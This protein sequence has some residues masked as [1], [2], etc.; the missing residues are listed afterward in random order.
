MRRALV[1]DRCTLA[2]HQLTKHVAAGSRAFP[3]LVASEGGRP[4]RLLVL[5]DMADR[6]G[7]PARGVRHVEVGQGRLDRA[8]A[9]VEHRRVHVA[10]VA[11]AEGLAAERPEPAADA[12]QRSEEHTSELQSLMRISYA[13][14]CLKINITTYIFLRLAC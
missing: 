9:G 11:D 5:G 6:R 13:V 10:H 14:F 12:G 8:E 3:R 1:V 2:A 4:V 7:H